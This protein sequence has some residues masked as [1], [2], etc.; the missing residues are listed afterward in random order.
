MEYKRVKGGEK[1]AKTGKR[2][3]EIELRQILDLYFEIEG[4]GIHEH[5]PKLHRMST[6]LQRTVRSVEAQL[7]MFRN[8]DK[9]GDYTYGNMNQICKKLW[10][11]HLELIKKNR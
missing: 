4:K 1:N 2:W 6:I 10:H 11:E 9:H 8:L 3:S 5:N 7:L